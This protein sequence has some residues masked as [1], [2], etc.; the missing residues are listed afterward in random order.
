[1]VI[2]GEYLF[3]RRADRH[4]G[5]HRGDPARCDKKWRNLLHFA[6]S[7]AEEECD[8]NECVSVPLNL[9]D[10]IIIIIREGMALITNKKIFFG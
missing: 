8:F 4:R 9:R 1:V 10:L 6:T 5:E 2:R 7:G 3:I